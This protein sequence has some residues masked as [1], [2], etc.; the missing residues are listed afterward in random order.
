MGTTKAIEVEA[1]FA[2]DTGVDVPDL[3]AVCMVAED[4]S[5]TIHTLSA[6]YYDTADLT[7]TDNRVVLRRRTGGTDAG[8]HVKFPAATGR[9]EIRCPAGEPPQPGTPVTPPE[10]IASQ[11]TALLRNRP[12]T[13][14]ARV[15]NERHV[16]RLLDDRGNDIAEFCDD[17]VTAWSFLPG[18]QKT[19]WREWEFELTDGTTDADTAEQMLISAAAVLTAAGA[20]D[21]DFPS[22]LV[23]AL[24]KS[25]SNV[26]RPA[27]VVPAA[28]TPAASV[29]AALSA[30]RDKIIAW[31]PAVRRNDDDSVHQMR[32]AT[33]Q[34]RSHLSTFSGILDPAATAPVEDEL[35]H[36]A[37]ILGR[38]RDA[39]V[40]A[41]M[42]DKIF[43]RE[44][45]A[46]VSHKLREFVLSGIRD[47]Y[48]RA[49]TQAVEFMSSPRYVALLDAVD[50][51]VRTPPLVAGTPAQPDGE[52]NTP[53]HGMS[54]SKRTGAG[55]K[56]N[57]KRTRRTSPG[58]VDATDKILADHLSAAFEKLA[59]QYR[60]AAQGLADS[61][62]PLTQREDRVH[63]MRKTAKKL[64]Y[65]VEAAGSHSGLKTAKLYRKLSVLQDDLGDFQDTVVVRDLL[66][67]KAAAAHE[68]GF[69]TFSLG[70]VHEIVHTAGKNRLAD[71]ERHFAKVDKA[72]RKMMAAAAR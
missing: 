21:S 38:A 56:K 29:V 48:T 60:L 41:E 33:R 47:D 53:S 15:D 25:S 13:A 28:G 26:A 4:A 63:D 42:L 22:K 59:G 58:T 31:D 18:G 50:G 37:K 67:T 49:W 24:G 9:L 10:E 6:I 40:V 65:A 51:L 36:L 61:S 3:S 43:D 44:T 34:M 5:C 7:L 64:R 70:I 66:A 2:V 69:D 23:A 14:I 8:W 16:H 17:H 71:L 55:G 72:Y 57:N 54:T 52:E 45:D 46:G 27:A 30:D 12:V 62:L 68:A 19:S 39:E 32:V 1:K 35:K 20:T 11:L